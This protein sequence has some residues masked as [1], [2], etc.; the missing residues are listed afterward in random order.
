MLRYEKFIL[1]CLFFSFLFLDAFSCHGF[2]VII[3]AGWLHCQSSEGLIQRFEMQIRNK[4][5]ILVNRVRY[6]D[7]NYADIL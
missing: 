1:A 5:K 3:D 4:I 2:Q 7:W 6:Q